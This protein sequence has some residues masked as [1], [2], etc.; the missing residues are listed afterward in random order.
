MKEIFSKMIT[1]LKEESK[2]IDKYANNKLEKYN[3]NQ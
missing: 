3:D 2:I 1:G